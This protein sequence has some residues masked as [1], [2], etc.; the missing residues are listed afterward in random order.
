MAR[1]ILSTDMPIGGYH[2]GYRQQL[3]Q[4]T[5]FRKYDDCLRMTVDCS[6]SVADAI[7]ARLDDARLAGI[8]RYGTHRQGSANLTCYIPSRSRADHVHFVDGATG[9]YAAA[10][11]KLKADAAFPSIS[12]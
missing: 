6:P 2:K 11:A 4:N 3:V 12:F 10:A 1:L 8:C 7:E 5:D 9:G